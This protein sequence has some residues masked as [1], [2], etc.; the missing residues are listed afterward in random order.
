M[1]SWG[2]KCTQ[3]VDSGPRRGVVIQPPAARGLP[4]C[5]GCILTAR[6]DVLRVGQ[7]LPAWEGFITHLCRLPLFVVSLLVGD[8]TLPVAVHVSPPPGNPSTAMARGDHGAVFRYMT[9][10]CHTCRTAVQHHPEV[11]ITSQARCVGRGRR[12]GNDQTGER[13]M[14]SRGA[15]PPRACLV[16]C[17]CFL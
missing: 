8:G 11:R 2:T 15:E 5:L 3:T 9:C 14:R 4:L 13:Q 1:A 16:T 17:G 12:P 10:A 6:S 7:G